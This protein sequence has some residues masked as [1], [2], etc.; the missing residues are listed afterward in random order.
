MGVNQPN[1]R[2]KHVD[3]LSG[4]SKPQVLVPAR[5][6]PVETAIRVTQHLLGKQNP[7]LFERKT[8]TKSKTE[9]QQDT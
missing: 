7:S 8:T 2:S 1:A 5:G 4:K 9:P 6:I 3:L